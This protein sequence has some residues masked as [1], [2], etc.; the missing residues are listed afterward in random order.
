MANSSRTTG[1]GKRI[2]KGSFDATA[3]S[4]D[5][6]GGVLDF[7]TKPHYQPLILNPTTGE[8]VWK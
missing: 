4:L 6:P 8:V 3:G 2:G 7:H 1:R 5:A